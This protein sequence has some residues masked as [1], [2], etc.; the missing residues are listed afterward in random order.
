[1]P[2]NLLK[3]Y[4]VLLELDYLSTRDRFAS[5]RGIFDRDISN[6]AI[7][8]FRGKQIRPIKKEGKPSMD[9]LFNH[10]IKKE[11]KD[12]KGNKT[13]KR[14][15][16]S[17]RSKRLHWIKHHIEKKSIDNIVIFSYEDRI[18]GKDT[19]RTYIYDKVNN[20][21]I[22]LEPQRSKIDYYL[23]TAYYFNEP[24]G[25]KQIKKKFKKRL[26]NIY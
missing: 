25:D 14:I 23:I 20:Y 5:L 9:T 10:L 13:G 7:F 19:I 22:I 12:E 8:K 3:R 26:D 17:D 4:P 18:K 2:T 24:G 15:Y 11:E 16:E 1:M 21:V 6:N